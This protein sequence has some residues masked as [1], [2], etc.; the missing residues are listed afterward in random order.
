MARRGRRTGAPARRAAGLLLAL[1]AVVLLDGCSQS[2][3]PGIRRAE[4]GNL[5]VRVPA[6]WS[7]EDPTGTAIEVQHWNGD[8]RR[9]DTVWR[10]ERPPVTRAGDRVVDVDEAGLDPGVQ[11]A[12]DADG[13]P[14]RFEVFTIDELPGDGSYVLDGETYPATAAGRAELDEAACDEG[15]IDGKAILFVVGVVSVIGLAFIGGLVAL[16]LWI[17]RVTNRPR[18]PF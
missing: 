5:E 11:Y 14:D 4:G 13:A 8:Q 9:Y 15:E 6:C 2:W 12:I 18:P 1:G 7:D 17:A 10:S 3:D 16:A